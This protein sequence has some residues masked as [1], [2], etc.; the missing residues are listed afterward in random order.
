MIMHFKL[1]KHVHGKILL[2]IKVNHFPLRLLQ[3]AHKETPVITP[4]RF[5]IEEYIRQET[6]C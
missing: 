3:H 6:L 5:L 2:M 4:Q 1:Y